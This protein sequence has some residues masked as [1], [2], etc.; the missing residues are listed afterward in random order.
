[1]TN[2]LPFHDGKTFVRYAEGLA[3]KQGWQEPRLLLISIIGKA[4]Y[5][6]YLNNKSQPNIRTIVKVLNHL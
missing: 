4:A 2:E 5:Y 3:R 1:M 6:F